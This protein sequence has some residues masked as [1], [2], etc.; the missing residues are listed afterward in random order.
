[1]KTA[2]IMTATSHSPQLPFVSSF[3]VDRSYWLSYVRTGCFWHRPRAQVEQV[4]YERISKVCSADKRYRYD[5]RQSQIPSEDSRV[6]CAGIS[7]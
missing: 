1:M 2:Y 6:C 4:T 5:V 3:T 7:F